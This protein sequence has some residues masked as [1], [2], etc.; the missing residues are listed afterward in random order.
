MEFDRRFEPA[1]IRIETG[2]VG[3]AYAVPSPEGNAAI[4]RMARTEGVF[5]DPVYTGKAVAGLLDCVRRGSIAQ[6]SRV[7]FVHCGGSPAL[8]PHAELLTR[9]RAG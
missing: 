2:Y 5:L 9:D 4:V 7:L 3:E 1:E 6:G 8:F